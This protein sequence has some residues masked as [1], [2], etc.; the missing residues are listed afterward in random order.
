MR[1]GTDRLQASVPFRHLGRGHGRTD[2]G[3]GLYH[4]LSGGDDLPSFIDTVLENNGATVSTAGKVSGGFLK[5][6][7][8]S[9]TV[10]GYHFNAGKVAVLIRRTGVPAVV[11]GSLGDADRVR[12]SVLSAGGRRTRRARP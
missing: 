6:G 11:M 10:C 3:R 4:R 1:D 12:E 5:N 8:S 9:D 7:Y 2:E